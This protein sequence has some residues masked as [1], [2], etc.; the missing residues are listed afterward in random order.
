MKAALGG[1]G[2]A[3]LASAC[4]VGPIALSLI[5]AGTGALGAA[6]VALVPYR[7]WF[8]AATVLLIGAAFYSAYRPIP[9]RAPVRCEP[10]ETGGGAGVACSP[11]SR[12]RA[13][14]VAWIAAV[15]ATGLILFPDLIVGWLA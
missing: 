8:I 5:G 2:A 11:R 1:I 7:P 10:N 6:T 4:C 12:R 9:T 15:V 13:R 3:A 14:L